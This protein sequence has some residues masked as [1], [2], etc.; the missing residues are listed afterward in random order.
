MK[1]IIYTEEYCDFLMQKKKKFASF[2]IYVVKVF[3]VDKMIVSGMQDVGSTNDKIH[4]GV[5]HQGC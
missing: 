3:K 1:Y 4:L 5:I 2:Q